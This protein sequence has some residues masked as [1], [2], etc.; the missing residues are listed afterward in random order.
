MKTLTQPSSEYRRG[1]ASK[2]LDCLWLSLIV[3]LLFYNQVNPIER[4]RRALFYYT[5]NLTL[6]TF[7]LRFLHSFPM[8][9]DMSL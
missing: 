1:D 9:F 5:S 2:R 6:P 7:R 8:A 4:T 3:T